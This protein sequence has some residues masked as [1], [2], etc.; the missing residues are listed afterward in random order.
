MKTD[1]IDPAGAAVPAPMP[2]EDATHAP[3]R[4]RSRARAAGA[5]RPVRFT[6]PGSP[7]GSPPGASSGGLRHWPLAERPRERL[8]A[9]GAQALSDCEL[10]ALFIRTGIPGH[11][12]V[13][14]GRL[15]LRRF[16]SLGGMLDADAT[17]LATVAGLGPA[18]IA[19]LQA[20]SEIV[21]RSLA[22]RITRGAAFSSPSDLGDYLQLLIGG[23]PHEVFVSL[24][25][26]SRHR[27]LQVEES[28]RGTLTQTA[29]YPRE[30]ARTALQ[31]NAA[32]LVVAHNH[33]SGDVQPSEP[34]RLLTGRLRN[35]LDL[36]DI[37]LL[38]HFIVSRNARLSFAEHG[39]L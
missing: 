24:Y 39:W 25:L 34:D 28:S 7:P 8:Y 20:I 32:S 3:A 14:V 26:D 12:A 36:L 2:G 15:L 16:G 11:D 27:L 23:R 4:R 1:T 37:R 18:K 38:D 17:Q 21:R 33:P 13:D 30:I 35:A 29:V 6:C 9:A 10:L 19:Q 5:G 22:Q 31:C